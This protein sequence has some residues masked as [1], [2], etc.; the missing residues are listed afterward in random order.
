MCW[1]IGS[2]L[3]RV[4]IFDRGQ[5]GKESSHHA[6]EREVSRAENK[7]QDLPGPLPVR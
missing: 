6:V 5:K 7:D 4:V 3:L 1:R 2:F